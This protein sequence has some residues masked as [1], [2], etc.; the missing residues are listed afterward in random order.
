MNRSILIASLVA[1]STGIAML[2]RPHMREPKTLT[3]HDIEAIKKANEK[4]KR[5]AE[6]KHLTRPQ[7]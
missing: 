5:K 3:K 6:K 1:A 2:P 4:R 7:V